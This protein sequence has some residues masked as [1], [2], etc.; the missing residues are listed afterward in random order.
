MSFAPKP[1]PKDASTERIVDNSNVNFEMLSRT[2]KELTDKINFLEKE[3]R[4]KAS[5]TGLT[6]TLNFNG[7]GAGEVLT[8]DVQGG[9]V[10]SRTVV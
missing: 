10:L 1:L 5:I 8:M 4:K 6:E 2:V 3:L 7:S 9:S